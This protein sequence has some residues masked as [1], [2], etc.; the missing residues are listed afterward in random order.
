MAFHYQA[1]VLNL[2]CFVVSM[3]NKP[4]VS[5]LQISTEIL[6]MDITDLYVLISTP[7][8]YLFKVRSSLLAP[9]KGADGLN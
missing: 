9:R 2:V 8:T 6:E 7:Y 4:L 1:D 5:L 3:D